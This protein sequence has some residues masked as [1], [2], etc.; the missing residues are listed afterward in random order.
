MRTSWRSES[1][2]M[3]VVVPKKS[4]GTPKPLPYRATLMAQ[5]P[6]VR[7]Q[8]R[9]TPSGPVL[10]SKRMISRNVREGVTRAQG[11]GVHCGRPRHSFPIAQALKL[12]TQGLSIRA[13]AA[14]IGFP[15]STVAAALKA[16]SKSDGD[17]LGQSISASTAGKRA[18][19]VRGMRTRRTFPL[20]EAGQLREQ[21]LSIR[22]VAAKIR[23]PPST[24]GA[25]LKAHSLA[26]AQKLAAR[27]E[28]EARATIR[29]EQN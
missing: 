2:S 26:Q 13:V 22:S 6:G 17:V 20:D 11:K 14:R 9:M 24:V 27:L 3:I 28:R 19:G 1:V 15:A 23:F 21:G 25:A 29:R 12:R 5:V 8:A 10:L 16:R 7:P 4:G 18:K